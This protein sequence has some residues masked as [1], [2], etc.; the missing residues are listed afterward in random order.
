MILYNVTVSVDPD[1]REA[2]VEWMRST[3]IPEVMATGL[4]LEHRFYRVLSEDPHEVTYAVQYLCADR[5]TYERYRAD[6]AP[7]LQAATAR[8]FGDRI[9]AFRTLL[10][11]VAPA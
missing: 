4:F 6:H 7:R 11:A 10:E 5:D 1:A 9:S 8:Q 2:W 3:H